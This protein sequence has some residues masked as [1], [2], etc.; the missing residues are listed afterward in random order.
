MNIDTLKEYTPKVIES[1]RQNS[2][3]QAIALGIPSMKNE[4]WKYT[5]YN[6][7]LQQGFAPTY[8][9]ATVNIKK[10]FIDKHS[11]S[12]NNIVFLNGIYQPELS[13][14]KPSAG[15][16]FTNTAN[17]SEQISNDFLIELNNAFA[18]DGLY[19]EISDNVILTDL[20]EVLYIQ[21]NTS[22]IIQHRNKIKIGKHAQVS[23]AEY[24][25]SY[26]NLPVYVNNVTHIEID[27][28]AIFD[29]YK[30]QDG[31][32]VFYITEQTFVQQAKNS[33]AT[34]NTF[35]LSGAITRNVLQ[36][37]SQDER[38]LSNMNGLYLLKKNEHVDNRTLVN[39]NAPNCESN[40]LYKGIIDGN[41]VGVFNGKIRVAQEAQKTN[42]FQSNRNILLSE[43][44]AIY[45]KPQLEIFADD[46]KCS[47]GATIA[48]I[49]ESE[50]FYLQA[51][52]IGKDVARGLLVYAFAGELLE[53]IKHEA[54]KLSLK[55]RI[56]DLLN[57]EI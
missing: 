40:E 47:H 29:S 43:D 27:E 6:K 42:A 50:L 26:D 11:V 32:E 55:K 53:K 17:T 54:L 51:R 12:G 24:Y 57:I 36:F 22:G 18:T 34:V 38:T 19:L 8:T 2:L 13:S 41:A 33:T 14:L 46:V 16:V 25:I 21:S 23:L 7:I 15:V 52:G 30:I 3:M 39:H 10:D 31:G 4:E 37:D 49:E 44:A 45:T 5:Y 35:S 9:P 56:A 20:I 28:R 1:T 48:Q